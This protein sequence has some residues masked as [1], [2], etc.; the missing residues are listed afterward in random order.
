[1]STLQA[2][3][4]FIEFQK[5]EFDHYLL[6]KF[7]KDSFFTI[8][9]LEEVQFTYTIKH[10]SWRPRVLSFAGRSNLKVSGSLL[11]SLICWK[12]SNTF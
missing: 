10:V 12:A 9:L 7:I 11:A 1:M 6:L 2:F 4:P 5:S 3:D 8:I